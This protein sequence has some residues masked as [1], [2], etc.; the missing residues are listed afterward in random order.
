MG[1]GQRHEPAQLAPRDGLQTLGKVLHAQEKYA[2]AAQNGDKNEK[3]IFHAW[4]VL[5]QI[6]AEG[7]RVRSRQARPSSVQPSRYFG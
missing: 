5:Y 3:N 6:F 4:R 2:E 1:R 7:G